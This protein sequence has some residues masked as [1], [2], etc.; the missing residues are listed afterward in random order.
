MYLFVWKKK[1]G[2]GEAMSDYLGRAYNARKAMCALVDGNVI[3]RDG[4][5][6]QLDAAG[7]LVTPSGS[8]PQNAISFCEPWL[9]YRR[10]V[11]K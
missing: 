8:F 3:E 10:E 2:G 11:P 9:V 1:G 6:L 5:R 7:N 4:L